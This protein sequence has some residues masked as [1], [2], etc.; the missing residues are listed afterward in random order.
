MPEYTVIA[1]P[2]GAGKS[3][4]SNDLS[5]LDSVIFDAD[6]VKAI[7][8]KQYPDLP[9]QSI[10][11]MIDSAYWEAE[12]IALK[13]K[14]DL[15]VESNLRNDFLVNRSIAFKDKGYTT[16]LIYMLLPNIE[17]SMDRVNLRVAQRGHFVDQESIKYNFENGLLTLIQHFKKFDNLRVINTSL[18]IGRPQIKTLLILERSNIVYVNP[19]APSWAKPVLD[20][21][22]EKFTIN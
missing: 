7:K 1:G 10:A 22:I 6:K 20:E 17:T 15:T 19:A 13:E 21:I 16:N 11:M 14:R 5:S 8:E 18:Y 9:D 3:T 2:N 12:E 4:Y